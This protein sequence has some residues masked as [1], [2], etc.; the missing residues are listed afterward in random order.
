MSSDIDQPHARVWICDTYAG[1]AGEYY[2]E[3]TAN[4]VFEMYHDDFRHFGYPK[5]DGGPELP[6]FQ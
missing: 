4:R 5:W 3:V 1:L 6:P 2:D